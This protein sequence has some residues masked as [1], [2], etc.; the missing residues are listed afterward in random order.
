MKTNANEI[1][2]RFRR[3]S[4]VAYRLSNQDVSGITFIHSRRASA[5][6]IQLD[7]AAGYWNRL[8]TPIDQTLWLLA[9]PSIQFAR[10]IFIANECVIFVTCE[11]RQHAERCPLL[12]QID[13]AMLDRR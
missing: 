3:H 1:P 10:A 9:R 5:L 7:L 2:T 12:G 8:R 11:R 6:S 4:F 13:G